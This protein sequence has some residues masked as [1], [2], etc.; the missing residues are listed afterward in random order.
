MVGSYACYRPAGQVMLS[1]AID[2]ISMGIAYA[3]DNQ[4]EKILVDSTQLTGFGPLSTS[5]RFWMAERFVSA[6]K[7][8]VKVALL[9]R[10]EMIDPER[11]GVTVAQNLGMQANVFDSEADALEWL[12][13][14][15]TASC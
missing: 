6:A 1:E 2:L 8:V 12:L 11:F 15:Q 4:V 14:D 10:T 5:A 3:R 9:A 7:S 13:S